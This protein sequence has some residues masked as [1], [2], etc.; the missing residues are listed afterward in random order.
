MPDS[1]CE[2]GLR[3]RL[4][5]RTRE[6]VV[7]MRSAL[8]AHE[9]PVIVRKA[10]RLAGAAGALGFDAL[11]AAGHALEREAATRDALGVEACLEALAGELD[12]ALTHRGT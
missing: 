12:R 7:A 5:L 3:E 4:L 10:H 11:G 9:F 1:P 8:A 2:S 6:D